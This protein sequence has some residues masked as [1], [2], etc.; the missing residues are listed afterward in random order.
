MTY[1]SLF[2][3]TAGVISK[4]RATS[5]GLVGFVFT[6]YL[7][8]AILGVQMFGGNIC[9]EALAVGNFTCPTYQVVEETNYYTNAYYTINF[10]DVMMSGVALFVV[11]VG[12]N[13][14]E[15][16]DAYSFVGGDSTRWFFV[17][18]YV[19]VVFVALNTTLSFIIDTY[20]TEERRYRKKKK[21]RAAATAT[22]A[23]A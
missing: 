22:A 8:F 9:I 11:M 20:I 15:V 18:W 19:L 1:T 17:A 16:V 10:N 4:I 12:N 3:L 2:D 7:V 23:G 5:M 6:L 21:R 14:N 13:W